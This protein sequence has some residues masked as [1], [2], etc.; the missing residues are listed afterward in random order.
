MERMNVSEIQDYLKQNKIDGWLIFD[1]RGQNYVATNFFAMKK[2]HMLTRRWFYFIPKKGKP[3]LLVHRIERDNFPDTPG[4]VFVYI[5]WQQLRDQLWALLNGCNSVA[6]EYSPNGTIPYVSTVDG[7]TLDLVRSLGVEVIS[8]ANLVQYFQC[9][10]NEDQLQSHIRA[11]QS[12]DRIKDGAFEFVKQKIGRGETTNEYEVQR[13]ILNR[14]EEYDLMTDEPPIVA[15]NAHTGNPHYAPGPDRY[16]NIKKDDFLLIDL[17]GKERTPQGVYGDIT[18]V[19]YV[20]E[21]VPKKYSDIFDIVAGARDAGLEL[22]KEYSK[23]GKKLQGWQVDARVR[24]HITKAGYG[25][26]FTHR[27]GH[28]LD[29]KLHGNGVNI[30]SLE[31]L[32]E[33]E[34]IPGLAFTIEPGIYMDEFGVRSECNVYMSEEGP[35]VYAPIQKEVIPILA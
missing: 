5:S 31:I 10:L 21:K 28:S 20:G 14:L 7:G 22:L 3:A 30:D 18:W 17:F 1:F 16:E 24:E 9:R 32:D 23:K 29:S 25:E 12:L 15:V 2:E 35:K 6:M 8:S 27:T 13:Y 26:Y 19:G 34:I 4:N 33:R 11:V